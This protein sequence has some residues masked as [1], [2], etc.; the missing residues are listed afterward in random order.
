LLFTGILLHMAKP[1][2]SRTVA[3]ALKFSRD[4]ATGWPTF[5]TSDLP[6]TGFSN[7]PEKK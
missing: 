4:A 1:E 5:S 2:R 7:A 3:A 6:T